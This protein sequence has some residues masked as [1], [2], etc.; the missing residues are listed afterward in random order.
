MHRL[1][2]LNLLLTLLAPLVS[3][4]LFACHTMR[5]LLLLLGLIQK[6]LLLLVLLLLGSVCRSRLLIS[7]IAPDNLLGLTRSLPLRRGSLIR[8]LGCLLLLLLRTSSGRCSSLS[9][10]VLLG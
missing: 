6:H 2:K 1:L 7:I 8:L 9:T 10:G 5:W 4:L 3:Q